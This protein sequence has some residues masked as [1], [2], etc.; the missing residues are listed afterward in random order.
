M[1]ELAMP[2]LSHPYPV[3][4]EDVTGFRRDGHVLLRVWPAR[5]RPVRSAR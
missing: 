3:A 5:A 2:S 4:E 1:T